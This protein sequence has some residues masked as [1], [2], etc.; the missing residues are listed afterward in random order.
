MHK[1]MKEVRADLESVYT[2]TTQLKV[3]KS[4]NDA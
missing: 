3:D 2:L 1:A 4:P